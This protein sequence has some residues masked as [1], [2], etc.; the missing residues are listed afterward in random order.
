MKKEEIRTRMN[1]IQTGAGRG[2]GREEKGRGRGWRRCRRRGPD[3]GELPEGCCARHWWPS[4]LSIPTSCFS[5]AASLRV[6][7]S[8]VRNCPR[9]DSFSPASLVF[10]FPRQAVGGGR[11]YVEE[12]GALRVTSVLSS[13]R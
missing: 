3:A 8:L 13:S 1:A 2:G 4:C 7:S 10:F 12:I 11:Y 6:R 9:F 5:P